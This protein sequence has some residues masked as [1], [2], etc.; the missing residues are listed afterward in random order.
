MGNAFVWLFLITKT[1]KKKKITISDEINKLR[2]T[3]K[4]L[5][6]PGG[7]PWDIEQSIDDL[8]S[9][10]IEESYELQ[11]AVK[12]KNASKIEEELGDVFYMLIFV[13]ELHRQTHETPLEE[14][15]SRV[16]NK[17]INRH[18]H[19]FGS[20][21][22]N[23]IKESLAQWEREKG[24]EKGRTSV[25]QSL[26]TQLPPLRRAIAVQRKAANIGLDWPSW[27]GVINK[28]YEE[29]DELKTAIASDNPQE[30]TEE[31]GDVFFTVVNLSRQL[32]VD[33]E[34]SIKEATE[35]FLKRFKKMELSAKDKGI[36]LVD[37]DINELEKL[38]QNSKRSV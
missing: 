4:I 33:P 38:W 29:I 21:S 25:M 8:A 36:D 22:A 16:H 9:Y 28:L 17:L 6:E 30:I 27:E 12:G 31:I 14:I 23:N 13:H 18:P 32:R 35:K 11:S 10:L 7:C 19:V 5:R 34:I 37:L 1:M 24:K 2:A 3:L 20:S 15:I 26:P